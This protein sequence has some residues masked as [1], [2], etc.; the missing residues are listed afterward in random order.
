VRAGQAVTEIKGKAG[1]AIGN[2][3]TP[4]NDLI[5]LQL[6]SDLLWVK[7]QSRFFGFDGLDQHESFVRV[8]K[9]DSV[10][11]ASGPIW[12]LLWL[13]ISLLFG[14]Y[15]AIIGIPLIIA[16]AIIKKNWLAIHSNRQSIVIFFQKTDR[17][18]V[19]QFAQ[20]LLM[21][22]RQTT[23]PQRPNPNS[24]GRPTKTDLNKS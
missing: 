24:A 10:T 15:T 20:T 2:I 1:Q 14:I 7:Q 12:W 19:Q 16:F 8:Q 5:H 21:A 3:V 13:G 11:V 6:R 4:T 17:D 22:A 18:R 9:I 23:L